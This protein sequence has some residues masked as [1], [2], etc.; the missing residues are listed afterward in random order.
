MTPRAQLSATSIEPSM[1]LAPFRSSDRRNDRSFARCPQNV[2]YRANVI[3]IE[4]DFHGLE[5]EAGSCAAVTRGTVKFSR[6]RLLGNVEPKTFPSPLA[7]GLP[8]SSSPPSL[9]LPRPLSFSLSSS[10]APSLASLASFRL[11]AFWVGPNL[12]FLFASLSLSL[13]FSLLAAAFANAVSSM[14]RIANLE[15]CRLRAFRASDER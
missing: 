9:F 6:Q 4:G 8:S 13:S 10:V 1:E 14:E 2:E 15:A 7:V 5:R 3:Q 11:P 12:V